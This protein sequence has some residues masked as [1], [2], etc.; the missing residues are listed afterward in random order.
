MSKKIK[1]LQ[2]VCLEIFKEIKEIC[3]NHNIEY[4]MIGGTLLG[5]VRHKGFI[6]WDDDLDI[7]LKREDYNKFLEIAAKKLSDKYFLQT[8]DTDPN[9]PLAFA[10]VRKN[11][12]FLEETH[13]ENIDMHK[14]IFVDVFPLD[15]MPNNK[16]FRKLFLLRLSILYRFS[17]IANLNIQLNTNKKYEVI[18]KII[19]VPFKLFRIP[20]KRYL[21]KFN[22][23]I[24]KYNK[25]KKSNFIACATNIQNE[26]IV[27]DKSWYDKTK[28]GE[29]ENIEVSIPIETDKSLR[30]SYG[31]YMQL[32]PESERVPHH[33]TAF[34][35]DK[36][37]L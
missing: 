3:D 26:K 5:A 6:P 20:S 23:R 4:F 22:K 28:K 25:S 32:P 12:T 19:R 7:G 8:F 9:Y 30:K 15:K 14:G 13:Y 29:F 21:E 11:N 1:D 17:L 18:L 35:I 34:S 33:A 31:D 10:K 2:L 36:D 24:Q 16:F 27:Y 37:T